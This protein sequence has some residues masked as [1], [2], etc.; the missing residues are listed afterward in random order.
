MSL[1][2]LDTTIASTELNGNFNDK[3]TA[4]NAVNA[5]A[6]KVYQYD[7]RFLTTASDTYMYFVAPD[8]LE[9]I[10]VGC[11][12]VSGGTFT[13]TLTA[14]DSSLVD[15]SATYLAGQTVVAT[16]AVPRYTPAIPVY[17]I[18][19][20]TYKFLLVCSN[21]GGLAQ[22]YVLARQFKRYR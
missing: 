9:L 20:I 13:A 1:T 22:A 15:I 3:L 4:L 18:K 16:N 14:V 17:L 19:G 12:K 2:T 11:T 5:V 6:G 10:T 7:L 8:D 21:T